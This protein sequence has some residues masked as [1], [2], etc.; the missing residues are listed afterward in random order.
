MYIG[1]CVIKAR[2]MNNRFTGH[3]KQ[4][5]TINFIKRVFTFNNLFLCIKVTK[6]KHNFFF[7]FQTENCFIINFLYFSKL[8]NL[9]EFLIS[10][11][12]E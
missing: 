12:N 6:K 9:I 7:F 4:R 3:F 1:F 2:R 5:V 11:K 10:L 8:F